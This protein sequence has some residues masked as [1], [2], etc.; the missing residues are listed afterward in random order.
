MSKEIV[1][2]ICFQI[3]FSGKYITSRPDGAT[4]ITEIYYHVVHSRRRLL[5]K[6]QF[7][8]IGLVFVFCLHVE[9]GLSED[10]RKMEKVQ[11]PSAF[12]NSSL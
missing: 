8:R 6:F 9:A 1:S 11:Y 5:S 12:Q 2:E 4:I 7:N 3:Y 10:L